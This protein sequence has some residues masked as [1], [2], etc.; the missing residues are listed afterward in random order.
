MRKKIGIAGDCHV[1]TL[2]AMT[3]IKDVR[4]SNPRLK[5]RWS[6]VKKK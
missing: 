4:D 1:A 5:A 3:D 6:D 2:L